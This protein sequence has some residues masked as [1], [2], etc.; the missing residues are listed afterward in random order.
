MET[1]LEYLDKGG[2]MMYVILAVS[3]LGVTVFLERAFDLFIRR[4]L[5]ARGLLSTVLGQVE[6]RQF[7]RAIDACKVASRHP[8]VGVLRAGI[9]RANRREKEIERAMEREMVQALPGLQK[10]VGLL[11]FLANSCTLLGL[12]GTIFGLIT[13]FASVSE[14]SAAARQQALAD[15]I[16]QAMYTTAFGIV[17]AVPLLYFHHLLSE[18]VDGVLNEMEGGAT[19]LLVAMTGAV[20]APADGQ[21][22]E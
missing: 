13:A 9:M 11:G 3:I 15:G 10:R 12:L 17:V 19:A 8:L 22:A 18:R 4:R 21:K 16:A 14:A 6:G 5:D 7:R 20:E 2:W 1:I